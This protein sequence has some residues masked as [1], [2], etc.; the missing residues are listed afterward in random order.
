MPQ[1]VTKP[2]SVNEHYTHC[3]THINSLLL[4]IKKCMKSCLAHEAL[5]VIHILTVL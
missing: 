3:Y 5:L 2:S 4:I 1:K